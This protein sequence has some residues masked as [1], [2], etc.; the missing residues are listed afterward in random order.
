MDFKLSSGLQ[1][2]ITDV[3]QAC[4]N[5]ANESPNGWS[6]G[7]KTLSRRQTGPVKSFYSLPR[8]LAAEAPMGLGS[9]VV[10]VG[11]KA[12]AADTAR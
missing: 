6:Q 9:C 11:G 5:P 3:P 2:L 7:E 10:E 1:H 4:G 12:G 8:L